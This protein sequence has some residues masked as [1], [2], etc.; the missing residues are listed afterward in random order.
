L[1]RAAAAGVCLVRVGI[2]PGP[3]SALI[4]LAALLATGALTTVAECRRGV[5][6]RWARLLRLAEAAVAA[7]GIAATHGSDSPLYPYLLAPAIAAG[8]SDSSWVALVPATEVIT[9][10]VGRLVA[11]SGDPV[12]AYAAAGGG[13]ALLAAGA[14]WLAARTPRGEPAQGPPDSYAAAYRLLTQLRTVSRQLSAGLDPPTL[15]EGILDRVCALAPVTRGVVFVSSGGDRLLPAASR[16][17]TATSR[18]AWVS[19]LSGENPF[20]EAWVSQRSQVL[21]HQLSDAAAGSALVMPLR[22]GLRSFGLLG[23]ETD[24]AGAYP[25]ALVRAIEPV[26]AAAALRLGSALLFEELRELATVQERRRLAREIHD[27]IAQELASLGYL[28]DGLTAE[29]K[30][31]QP[32]AELVAGLRGLRAELSR[33]ISELRLSIFELRSDVQAHGGLGAA[34]SDYVRAVG[35][36]SPFTVHLTLDEGPTR[37]PADV[38]AELLRIA[39]EAINNARKHAKAD[40]LWVDCVVDPPRYRLRVED[41][42]TGL[43]SQRR[44]SYGLEIMRERATRLRAQFEVRAREPRGTTVEVS[45]ATPWRVATVNDEGTVM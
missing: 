23:I 8:L 11:A 19:E 13:W 15:A 43:V 4:W 32:A 27:G 2:G 39:Q 25:P 30:A 20:A 45:S 1:V 26:V 16:G 3:V 21:S 6:P 10:A 36:G 22:T 42:G 9:L 5:D 17:F 29:A 12:G 18:P 31:G 14:G 33:V 28:V 34:L 38:E 37:L 24:K 7:A 40:N 44:G 35:T 41:D